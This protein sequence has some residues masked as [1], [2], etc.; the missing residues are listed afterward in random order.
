MSTASALGLSVVL[1][2][3]NAFFVGAE[4]AVISA[5]RTNIEPMAL[6]GGRAA[7]ITLAAMERVSLMLACAQLGITVCSL[8]LGY[9]GE[10]AIAHLL[11]GP[12]EGAG[13]PDA[14][15]H[16]IAFALALGLIGFLHVVLGEWCPRTSRSPAPTAQRS[17]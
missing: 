15:V 11:E 2:A 5:R 8:G 17:S 14:L 9:L 10:P 7:R 12:F 1:L 16:P 4:F 3:L 13:V 6:A